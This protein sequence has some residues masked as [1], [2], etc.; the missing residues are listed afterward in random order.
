[1]P[2]MRAAEML[3]KELETHAG[4][5]LLCASSVLYAGPSEHPVMAGVRKSAQLH[6]LHITET[7]CPEK[8][9]LPADHVCLSESAAGYIYSGRAMRTLFQVLR[10]SDVE[11]EFGSTATPS[12]DGILAIGPEMM[13]VC[14]QWQLRTTHQTIVWV[15]G[16]PAHVPVF[17]FA[18]GDS[19]LYGIPA[20]E[21][22]PWVKV[23]EH[24]PGP[25]SP[26]PQHAQLESIHDR[27]RRHFG[28]VHVVQTQDCR[29][30]NS[31]NGHFIVDWIGSGQ[32]GISACSGHGFKFAP[33]I[34]LAAVEFYETRVR[35]EHIT[36][37]VAMHA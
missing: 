9:V 17:G 34:A 18:D 19:F 13:R 15:A 36:R 27:L 7:E 11:F 4:Q 20:H 25:E 10:E 24:A 21:D 28:E 1:V 22:C 26:V 6:R 5:P 12:A 3:W 2:I 8:V 33:A 23:G 32:L 29:Y 31:P 14:P 30:T 35:P 16:I 37:F